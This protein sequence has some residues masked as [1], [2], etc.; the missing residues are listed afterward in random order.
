MTTPAEWAEALD[1]EM[2]ALAE[3]IAALSWPAFVIDDR[4]TG[5]PYR[6]EI[7]EALDAVQLVVGALEDSPTIRRGRLSAHLGAPH[8]GEAN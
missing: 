8:A 6:G 3:L 7:A 1:A 4:A 2:G 5:E